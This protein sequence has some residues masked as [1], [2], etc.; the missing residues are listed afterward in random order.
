MIEGA[1]RPPARVRSISRCPARSRF[2]APS[3]WRR[4]RSEFDGFVALGCVIRGET[5][6][7]DLICGEVRARADGSV[8]CRRADRRSACSPSRTRRR[9]RC[10]PTARARTRATKPSPPCCA[11]WGCPTSSRGPRS[12]LRR[13]SRPRRSARSRRRGAPA[14]VSRP[15]RRSTRWN[16]PG[17]RRVPSSL[18]SWK[19]GWA[20]MT[21]ASRSR[22]RIRTCS[23]QWSTAWCTGRTRSTPRS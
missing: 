16:R 15:C 10:A 13:R 6:H 9:R 21:K 19:T 23:G 3:P 17:S 18:T 11:W 2:P 5:S 7:Y 22:K 4:R 8:A 14:R 20:S 1:A 12:E